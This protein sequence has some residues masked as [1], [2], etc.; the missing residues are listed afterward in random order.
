MQVGIVSDPGLAEEVGAAVAARLARVLPQRIQGEADW[1][2]HHRTHPLA[3]GQQ[4]RLAD[5]AAGDLPVD[6]AWDITV[7]LTD[8]PRREGTDPVEMETSADRRVAVVSLPALG[9]IR[10]NRRAE[11]VIVAAVAELLDPTSSTSRP[12]VRSPI[13]SRLR[14]LVGMVRANRPWQLFFGL[15]RAM[16][17]VFGTAALAMLNSIGWQLGDSLGPGRLAGMAAL[18]TVALSAWL[19][20]DHELWERPADGREQQ[21]ARLYNA[22]TA[23]TLMLG[24]VCLYLGLF[25]VLAG[26][27]VIIFD[28]HVLRMTL[29]HAPTWSDRLGIAWFATSA[30]MV[31]GALGS[32]LENDDVVRRAAY[33]ERQRQRRKHQ[34]R[35]ADQA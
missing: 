21:L 30:A 5:I 7:L 3:T 19:I 32:G 31:G 23:I 25:I 10:L 12:K 13:G 29:G 20:V 22:A 24:V 18:S 4:V 2:V 26:I 17:G 34:E 8:L 6:P 28:P 27:S 14:L 11:R 9:A 1:R 35:E 16:A 33:G 15:S